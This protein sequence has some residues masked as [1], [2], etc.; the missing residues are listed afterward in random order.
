MRIED[1]K[2]QIKSIYFQGNKGVKCL[3]SEGQRTLQFDASYQGDRTEF[4]VIEYVDATEV[5]RHNTRYI[6]SIY[7]GD[8]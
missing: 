5:A 8:K 7:W 1:N 2:R 4:W 6:T 3:V